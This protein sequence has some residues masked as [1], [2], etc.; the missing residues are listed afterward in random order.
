[1]TDARQLD[2]A[3]LK[4]RFD[5]RSIV[6]AACGPPGRSGKFLCCF[7]D[8]HSPSLAIGRDGEHFRCWA[9]GERGDVFDFVSKYERI[10]I[11]EAARRLAEETGGA[12]SPSPARTPKPKAPPKPA[13]YTNPAWQRDLASLVIEAEGRLWSAEGRGARAWLRDRGLADWTIGAFRLGW[14][15]SEGRTEAG[16]R[17]WPGVL[18]PWPAPTGWFALADEPDGPRWA[19]ANTRCFGP[20]FTDPPKPSPKY[21]A[22][23][24]STRG[25]AYPFGDLCPGRPSVVAEGEFD[26]MLGHQEFG[27]VANCLTVGGADQR[28]QPG[29]LAALAT[30]PLWLVSFDSDRAGAKGGVKW[31]EFDPERFRSATLPPGL[32]DLTKVFLAGQDLRRW[33]QDELDRLGWREPRA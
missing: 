5:L 27:H 17:Y 13:A 2:F 30:S 4:A 31:Y 10:T 24:D 9:C 19:G 33:L 16:F 22:V 7:H 23:D 29:V 28:P 12:M 18:I 14:L 26:A 8:D 21:L 25:H 15:P 20:G 6:E 1:M 3:S 32:K 11:G